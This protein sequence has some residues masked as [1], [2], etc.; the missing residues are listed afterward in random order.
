MKKYFLLLVMLLVGYST[1]AQDIKIKKKTI[2]VDGQECLKI[3]KTTPTSFALNTTDGQEV[4]HVNHIHQSPYVSSMYQKITFPSTDK[5]LT[6][7]SYIFTNKALVKKLI[8]SGVLD[9]C[10]V[11]E[12]KIEGFIKRYDENIEGRSSVIII[13]Q[14]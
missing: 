11:V 1:Q 10:A 8:Q 3:E 14:Q 7:D 9:D 5:T 12:D 13:Q 2:Y 6:T 4:C